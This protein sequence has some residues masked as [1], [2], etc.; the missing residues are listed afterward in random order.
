MVVIY[1]L[2]DLT[3]LTIILPGLFCGSLGYRE[4]GVEIEGRGETFLGEGTNEGL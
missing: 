4:H 1:K 3:Y 2:Q